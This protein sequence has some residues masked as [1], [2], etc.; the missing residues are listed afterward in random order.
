[1]T[2]SLV[3]NKDDLKCR[4][5]RG[6]RSIGDDVAAHK[7]RYAMLCFMHGWI[8]AVFFTNPYLS[9]LTA[10]LAVVE[11]VMIAF[12][13]SLMFEAARKPGRLV[14]E[15]A[16]EEN[17]M[18]TILTLKGKTTD[19]LEKMLQYHL[20]NG[21]M[22]TADKISQQLLNMIDGNPDPYGE[23][24]AAAAAAAALPVQIAQK[25]G[26]AGVVLKVPAG[27]SSGLPNWMQDGKKAAA[28]DEQQQQQSSL[29][30]WMNS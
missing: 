9:F 26:E 16:F 4:T 15:W 10:V 6:L 5:R 2:K 20:D 27:A 24:A 19:E 30:D 14:H 12:T 3:K 22:E 8:L 28:E 23:N 17:E 1:M 18:Q 21:H 7:W 11:T 13:V 25:P 29:P